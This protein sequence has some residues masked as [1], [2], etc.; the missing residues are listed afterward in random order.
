MEKKRG[1]HFVWWEYRIS[2]SFSLIILCSLVLAWVLAAPIYSLSGTEAQDDAPLSADSTLVTTGIW[3][4][5]AEIM[6]LSTSGPAWAQVKDVA[7]SPAGTPNLSDQDDDTNVKVLAKALAFVRTNQAQ[8]RTGVVDALKVVT[9]DNTENGGQTLALG[10]ELAAYV[11]AADLID[12]ATYDSSLDADFR[13]KIRDL[14]T[15]TLDGK[16]LVSTHEERP[17]NWGT[18]AGASRAAVAAYLGDTAEL[19]RTAQVFHGWVGDRTAYSGFSYGDS[20]WQCN[21]SEP[22]GINPKGCMKDGHSIDG[23]LPEEMRRGGDFR[24]PPAPT[25]YAWEGLQGAIVQAEILHRAGYDTWNW[26]DK[27]LLRAVEFLE[28]IGWSADGDDRWQIWL[29][30]YS[31]GTSFTAD[32]PVSAGKNMGWTDWSHGGGLVLLP[33]VR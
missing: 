2:A 5:R 24:W 16:T 17:N 14:L 1:K 27:A 10:R 21:P 15:K 7:D 11:I 29:I 22:V 19:A 3:I 31:Y 33:L 18:H 20:S 26:E 23:A 13:V 6:R 25:G 28:S 12:L 9:Y 8:Y 32:A 30:N 4:S